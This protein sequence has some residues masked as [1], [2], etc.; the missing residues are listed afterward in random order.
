MSSIF[1]MAF[2]PLLINRVQYLANLL[3]PLISSNHFS[4]DLDG[5]SKKTITLSASKNSFV[6]SFSIF[7]CFT[8]FYCFIPLAKI[9]NNNSVSSCLCFWFQTSASPLNV[10]LGEGFLSFLKM[11]LFYFN[12]IL[13][14][15]FFKSQ[16]GLCWIH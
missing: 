12:A 4:V 3:N 5:F 1:L 13:L 10:M 11:R 16:M 6:S 14:N 7:I 9:L 15:G 8:S 2:S